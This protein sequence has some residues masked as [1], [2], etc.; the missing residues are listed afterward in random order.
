MAGR[1]ILSNKRK[2][3]IPFDKD[4]MNSILKFGAEKL[5]SEEEDKKATKNLEE[6]DIDEVVIFIITIIIV[7]SLIIMKESYVYENSTNRKT[8]C[9]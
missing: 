4:E 1:T 6:L 7:M 8:C 3:K 2:D 5:F 9:I